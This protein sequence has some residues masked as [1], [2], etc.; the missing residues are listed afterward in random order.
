MRTIRATE[1][2]ALLHNAQVIES[3]GYGLKVARLE[4]GDFLKIYRR[5]R[6]LSSALWSPP[7]E[8]FAGNAHKLK[9]LGIACPEIVEL[10]L[11]PE[12]RLN[13]VQYRPLPGETLRNHWR[14]VDGGKRAA[15][16]RQ[17]GA[18]LAMLH[19]AGVYFR[20]L[21][22]GN[23]L[24]LPDA[25]L[26]L[27]DLSDMK[28]EKH[29]LNHWKRKRNIQHILRYPEDTAWLTQQHRQEWIAGYAQHSDARHAANFERDLDEAYP[30]VD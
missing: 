25:S 1:L 3:D 28:V 8:R 14:Q 5:K 23:V 27:I 12:K 2:E 7:A 26:G 6:L 19:Q 24:L 11:I 21:H 30:A 13:V 18:F 15:E 9:A 17:F 29:P 4:G 16:V 20:S 22:L 10:L